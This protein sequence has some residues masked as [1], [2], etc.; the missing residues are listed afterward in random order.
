MFFLWRR[1]L[2]DFHSLT[3]QRPSRITT[4]FALHSGSQ[5]GVLLGLLVAP[6]VLLAGPARIV[7][8]SCG[9]RSVRE[10][11]RG[12]L[13]ST[14]LFVGEVIHQL[15]WS[16]CSAPATT[17]CRTGRSERRRSWERGPTCSRWIFVTTAAAGAIAMVLLVLAAV[18]AAL[19]G[20]RADFALGDKEGAARAA[21]GGNARGA[22]LRGRISGAPP[23]SDSRRTTATSSPSCRWSVGPR[24][25]GWGG[26]SVSAGDAVSCGV[27]ERCSSSP[28]SVSCTRRTPRRSTGRSG[29]SPSKRRGWPAARTVLKAASNGTT[30]TRR[31]RSSSLTPYD[32]AHDSALGF[33]PRRTPAAGKPR[34][35]TR[36][37]VGSPRSPSLD[38]GAAA[39]SLLIRAPRN[40][41][42]HG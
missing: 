30:I 33:E 10:R 20:V 21:R 41:Q 4:R 24:R 29:A 15:P 37:R 27:P 23:G 35:A 40:L 9:A 17:S 38:R 26:G 19:D 32:R 16:T 31:R 13:G 25:A 3:L 12:N 34:A 42:R 7:R 8:A 2:T 14:A 22:G 5:A 6:A 39:T 11:C 1:S 28:R 36:K 18:P